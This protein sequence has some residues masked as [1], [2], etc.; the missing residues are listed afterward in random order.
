MPL[1]HSSKKK[2]DEKKSIASH[3]KRSPE[4]KPATPPSDSIH[5]NVAEHRQQTPPPL[6]PFKYAPTLSKKLVNIGGLPV[7]VYGLDELTPASSRALAPSPPE[8]CIAIHMHGRGGT[9][10]NEEKIVRQIWDRVD[11]DR[12][13]WLQKN[14]QG[15][16]SD[17]KEFLIVGF[18]SRNHGHR[19]TNEVGQK[20]WKQG[21]SLHGLDLYSMIG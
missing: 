21:N 7:S 5:H 10:N 9:A 3:D 2:K 4:G 15:R 13:Q 11:R 8:V 6:R 14:P 1:F 18:D 20:G 16:Y 17:L 19:L 12:K